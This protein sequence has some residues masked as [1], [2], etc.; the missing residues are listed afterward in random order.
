[1]QAM[2]PVIGIR[3]LAGVRGARDAVSLL[4]LVWRFLSVAGSVVDVAIR[5]ITIVGVVGRHREHPPHS[6]VVTFSLLAVL[7][8]DIC[9]KE[10][11]RCRRDVDITLTGSAG[12]YHA[13]EGR[14][15]HK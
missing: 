1:M 14:V 7:Q 15:V 12:C 3:Q 11:N 4:V 13:I 8:C 9:R 2:M 6:P 5:A 10:G